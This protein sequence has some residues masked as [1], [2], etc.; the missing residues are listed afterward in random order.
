MA[1]VSLGGG[2]L[3]LDWNQKTGGQEWIAT[4]PFPTMLDKTIFL[5]SLTPYV[6][7]PG[8]QE[9]RVSSSSQAQPGPGVYPATLAS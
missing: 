1:S 2:L 9:L 8:L 4:I 7:A 5:L 3:A 6:R